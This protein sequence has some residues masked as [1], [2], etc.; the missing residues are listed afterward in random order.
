[1]SS[2]IVNVELELIVCEQEN[3]QLAVKCI[4]GYCTSGNYSLARGKG[5]GLGAVSLLSYL[6]LLRHARL[7]VPFWIVTVVQAKF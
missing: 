2:V 7:S 4:I 1:M 5:H 3:L 6:A